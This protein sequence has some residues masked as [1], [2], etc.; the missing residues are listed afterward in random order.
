ML[1][2]TKDLINSSILV[3]RTDDG[4]RG[5][6]TPATVRTGT[7]DHP[8]LAASRSPQT[9]AH[10]YLAWVDGPRLSNGL[11]FS[12]S[13]DGGHSFEPAR[14]LD[15]H[16]RVP[17]TA[18][19][20]DGAIHIIYQVF[21]PDGTWSVMV[22]T[23]GDHGDTFRDPVTLA[24][25]TPPAQ[26]PPGFVVNSKSSPTI[27]ATPDGRVYAAFPDYDTATGRFT[28]RLLASP[29]QGRRWTT[30]T[31]AASTDVVYLQPMV[32]VNGEGRVGVSVFAVAQSRVGVLLFVS[33]H[34]A[35]GFQRWSVTGRAFD[36]TLAESA[37]G[38]YYLGDHQGLAASRDAF[39][40]FWNDTRTGRMEI[41]A[42]TV[43]PA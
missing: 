32:A 40:P 39:H 38:Q 10:L 26:T 9:P 6:T 37:G 23:S 19:G 27:A 36:A 42:G 22:T 1:S 5:F 20:P 18:T 30:R 13:T 12:R 11:A 8:W 16:G 29:D 7:V 31:L 3:W 33:G 17:M 4:G 35:T 41:F 2:A 25:V 21:Q 43:R 28:L 14:F 34:H 24:H 15:P